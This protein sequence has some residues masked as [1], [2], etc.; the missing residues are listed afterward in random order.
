MSRI[1][2]Y[3]AVVLN[4]LETWQW[5]AIAGVFFTAGTVKGILGIGLP[6]VAI[7]MITSITEPILAVSLVAAPALVANGWQAVQTGQHYLVLQRFWPLLISMAVGTMIGARFLAVADQLVIAR[8]LGIMVLAFVVLRIFAIRLLVSERTERRI[9]I[10]IGF[11]AG[12]IGGATSIFGPVLLIYLV[13]LN[14]TKDM[15]VSAMAMCFFIGFVPLIWS[16]AING[17]LGLHQLAA[18]AVLG[19]IPV[20]AGLVAGRRVRGIVP[21]ALFERILLGGIALIG[22]NLIIRSL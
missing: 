17:L 5:L 18:S 14:L 10:P 21:Q 4:S 9:G 16:L 1:E 6:L 20:S 2:W 19:A 22:A 13:A 7:P 12:L 3:G 11:I 15:F 8:G